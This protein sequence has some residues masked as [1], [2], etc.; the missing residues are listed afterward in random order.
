MLTSQGRNDGRRRHTAMPQDVDGT[1]ARW[2]EA[3]GAASGHSLIMRPANGAKRR[4]VA[5]PPGRGATAQDSAPD[6]DQLQMRKAAAFAC[7]LRPG[8]QSRHI[9][10]AVSGK[11]EATAKS[12]V[13]EIM[14]L[15][16]RICAMLF[17][18]AMSSLTVLSARPE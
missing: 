11:H 7:G 18:I 5:P 9:L 15:I 6:D 17:G 1:I 2:R 13:G 3:G 16:I 12:A 14:T 4:R 8:S 10:R